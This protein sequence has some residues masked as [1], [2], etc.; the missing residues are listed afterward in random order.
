MRRNS[1][2]RRFMA[3]TTIL[4]VSLTVTWPVGLAAA[5]TEVSRTS[6]KEPVAEG[7]TVEKINIRTSDGP[8]NV[9][10]MTV[11]LT[12]QYVKVDTMVGKNG[13]LTKN[14]CVSNMANET[15]AVAGIN[16]DFFQM[17]EHAPI[18]LTVQSGEL[19][20]SP[21]QRTDTYGFGLTKDNRPIFPI[22]GFQGSVTSPGGVQFQLFGINKPTYFAYLPD[23]NAATDANRL[24]MFTPRWGPQ[25]RGPL[26]GLIGLV[27]M[28]VENDF[29]TEIRI[30][31]PPTAI[32]SNG[33]I[34]VGHG[35]A[36]Q[37][38]T[39]N[40]KA[41][42]QVQVS[43]QV[44]P[45]T[46]NLQMAVGG[47]A[48][49]V[50]QGKRH[51]FTQT[52]SGEKARTGIGASRDGKTLYLVVVEGGDTSRGMTQAELADF[53]AS[54][55]AWT[56]VNL[57]GGGSSTMAARQLGDQTVTLL[58]DPV[59]DSQRSIPNGIGIF[60]TAP[61]GP[62]AGLKLSGPGRILVGTKKT[63]SA[64]GYDIH[65]N[66]Y[67]LNQAD[68]TWGISPNLGE[69]EG[70]SFTAV[71]SGNGSITATYD[72]ITQEYPVR[73][74]GSG[75]I[76]RLEMS[77]ANI[78]LNPN[79]SV[80]IIVKVTTK[81]GEVINLQPGEYEVELSDDIVTVNGSKITA[82]DRTAAGR[83]TVKV[84]STSAVARVTVG[85]IE[86]PLYGFETAKA[87]KY[88][89]YPV[90]QVPGSFR[91]TKAN[92]PTF[93][94]AGAARLEY[95]FSGTVKTVAAYG[96]FAGGLVLPGQPIGLGLWVMGDEGNGH[97]L[98]AKIT[99]AAGV[100]KL[101][102]FSK[103]INWKGWKHITTDIPAD[104]KLPVKLTDIYL[105]ETGE[106]QRDK[107]VIF[108]D[109]LSV[110]GAPTTGE[111]EPK[112]PE[113]LLAQKEFQPGNPSSMKL[114][115]NLNIEFSNPGPSVHTIFARQIWST[116]L[117]TP[118]YNPVMPLYNIRGTANGDDEEKLPGP[119]KIQFNI[120]DI[121]SLDKIRVMFRDEEKSA[122]KQVP[123]LVDA[124][125]G[126]VTAKTNLLGVFG[127]MQDARPRP[128][129]LDTSFNWAKDIISDMAA[130]EIVNGYPDGRFLPN[131][132]ITR[133]E[134]VTLLANTL[135]W[136]AETTDVRFDDAIPAWAQG[137]VAAA[138]N[139]GVVRGY[140]DG[141]FQPNRVVNRAEMAVM[142]DIALSLAKSGQPS[143]YQDA[144]IIPSWAVQAIRNTKA[145]G[146]MQGS[147]NRF[148][149]KD[150]A[151]RAE[152]TAVMAKALMYYLQS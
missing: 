19:V 109:E 143:N 8:I 26:K 105:V 58:N 79:E 96:N 104:V 72:N 101:L 88:E 69:F 46:D 94:G 93:R 32:P 85:G 87:M 35:T 145:T 148:R 16:G 45:E 15:G 76:A 41:G 118:G 123:C 4:T 43:Y 14:Q 44:T 115:E 150:V 62:L 110:I 51:W 75:D 50:D 21:A 28:V 111:A 92:E 95:D 29:V 61:A 135:G 9:D 73:I 65:Y 11:D 132:G 89:D 119:M 66:P 2:L 108:F 33:Y 144:K 25:S 5:Y 20:T 133:G 3:W 130:R 57:D 141:T 147:G 129:Y 24:N 121:T 6:S 36:A 23:K 100:E 114:G 7:V 140:A 13:T 103:D 113:E 54:I 64:K 102:D 138:V 125:K 127:L 17:N 55:G 117:P 37:Y 90:G 86:K 38:L 53:M 18:G 68:I 70:N 151:N 116:A 27:E 124:V 10:V 63:F 99:D 98:R 134:F 91:L 60:S 112:Q 142:L 146:V 122:W 128:A 78:A 67:A 97:W 74:L 31:Q 120:N 39:T 149:P 139:R 71:E 48:L 42:D 1:I 34:L 126:T 106:A 22:Y 49:I 52:V 40:F 152:A 12:N 47:L 77:P 30:D 80:N 56:A 84:D 82:G 83:L 59:Y 137:S 131:K 136:A 81:Q 107:G